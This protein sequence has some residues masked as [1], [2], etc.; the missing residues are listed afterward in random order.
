TEDRVRRHRRARGLVAEPNRLYVGDAVLAGDDD[1]G[2][3]NPPAL[4]VGTQHLRD[5]LQALGREPD[6]L[7]PG[8]RQLGGAGRG[9][10]NEREDQREDDRAS[11]L[12]DAPPTLRT[13]APFAASSSHAF[14]VIA[15][16]L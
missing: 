14:T 15:S 8:A 16:M 2:A 9:D 3:G 6:L 4:D 1:D 13:S 10:A 7:G 5:A 11:P 12:H